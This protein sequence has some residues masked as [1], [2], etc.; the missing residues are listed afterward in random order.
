MPTKTFEER[1][2]NNN[3]NHSCDVFPNDLQKINIGISYIPVTEL[4]VFF[5]ER[6]GLSC[7]VNKAS[8]IFLLNIEQWLP[9]IILRSSHH[10]W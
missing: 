9:P 6:A 3:E 5:L 8:V 4:I 10:M 1:H 2:W 7:L